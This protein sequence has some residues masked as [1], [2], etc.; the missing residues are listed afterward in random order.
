MVVVA[1][2]VQMVVDVV[3]VVVV[4]EQ[5]EEKQEEEER[6]RRKGRVDKEPKASDFISV[7]YRVLHYEDVATVGISVK[8]DPYETIIVL[9]DVHGV[10]NRE[11]VSCEELGT[12]CNC[13]YGEDKKHSNIND[14]VVITTAMN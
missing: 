7:T 3:E 13:R 14:K 12:D 8:E 5:E 9:L 4:V 1:E 2:A 10:G 11:H 6:S